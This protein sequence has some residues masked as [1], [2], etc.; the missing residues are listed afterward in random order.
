MTDSTQTRRPGGHGGGGDSCRDCDPDLL[1][2]L[3]CRAKGL[4]ARADYNAA[5]LEALG[6]ARDQYE[7]A[8]A[9]YSAA[10]AAA[11]PLVEQAK[12]DLKCLLERLECLLDEDEDERRRIVEKIRKAFWEVQE[13]IEECGSKTGCYLD[14]DCDFDDVRDCE[15]YD[16]PARLADIQQRTAAAEACFADLISIP[17]DLPTKV[18]ALQA[19]VTAISDGANGD[20]TREV[21]VELYAAALV[22]RQHA[23][24]IWRGFDNVNDFVDCVCHALTCMLRGHT[25][26]AILVGMLAVSECK[27]E[28]REAACELLRSRTAEQ[29]VAVYLRHQRGDRPAVAGGGGTQDTSPSG[30]GGG[31]RP[32]E[33]QAGKDRQAARE[34][35][36]REYFAG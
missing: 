36:E 25:A 13:R 15:P 4:Q 20:P 8:R 32:A 33:D 24:D 6:T 5:H 16:V 9:A 11:T 29:V 18:A 17:T 23:H 3:K 21:L 1:D 7:G 10:R 27:R 34:R 35:A 12:S 28:S 14:D 22:A 19:E 26:I 31:D 2:A 30:G